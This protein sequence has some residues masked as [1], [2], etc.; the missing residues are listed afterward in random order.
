MVMLLRSLWIIFQARWRRRLSIDGCS[1]IRLRV[2]PNDLDLN[3]HLN[4]GRYFSAAD[5][6][7]FD[8]W[9]R[10]GLWHTTRR[11]GLRPMAGDASARF[12]RSLQPFQ[13]YRLETRLLGWDH[14]WFFA[15]HRFMAR[16]RTCAVVTV[17]YLF[18]AGDGRKASPAE[19]L[20]QHGW[21]QPA[22]ELPSWVR[23]WSAGQDRLSKSLRAPAIK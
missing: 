8:W 3:I 4:N 23:D 10:T 6:G 2:W 15:E 1:R 21:Q 18:I 17:R 22:P 16:Q 19:V 9:L 14:K 5:I 11:L 20:T 13:R 7:R 12:S